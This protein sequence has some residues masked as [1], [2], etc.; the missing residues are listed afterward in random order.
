MA[1]VYDALGSKISVVE[2][3]DGLIPGADRDLVK[4][5]HKRIEKRYEAIYLK[6]KVSKIEAKKEGLLVT[7]DGEAAPAP[8]LFDRVLMAVGR[9]PMAGR[10]MPKPLA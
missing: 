8:Q 6:T 9:R 1:T 10:S 5:L 4:P 3:A 7:F 2:L